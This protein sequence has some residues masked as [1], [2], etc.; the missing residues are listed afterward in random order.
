MFHYT[1]PPS[2]VPRTR[3]WGEPSR[4]SETK[5]GDKKGT[6]DFDNYLYTL[7]SSSFTRD[8]FTGPPTPRGRRRKEEGVWDGG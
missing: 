7:V 2:D 5:S 1:R 3:R 8:S 6:V 4:V